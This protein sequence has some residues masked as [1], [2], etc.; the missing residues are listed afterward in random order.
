[1]TCSLCGQRKARRA[2]PAL[3]RQICAVCCGTKR[4]TEIKCP[5]DCAYLVSSHE[6]PP[7]V[8]IRQ[9][10]RDIGLFAQ[11][12]R[13]FDRRQSQL[14]LATTTFIARYEPPELQPLIDDD[15]VEAT[16]ALAATFE[17]ASRGL[18]Y[19]P[20]PL[21]LPAERLATALKPLL[22]EAGRGGGS[23]FERDAGV[24]LRRI[25]EAVRSVGAAYP[26]NRRAYLDL[27]AR[28]TAKTD[29]GDDRGQAKREASRVIVP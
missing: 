28:V 17:T 29:G 5:S 15:V 16:E 12:L 18:I 20:R 6:H 26:E 10:Q 3:G 24:M 2:C 22:A 1:M 9:H 11:F 7:A 14:F 13:N 27:L 23:A 21:S 19:E 4:L 25:Q 8:A